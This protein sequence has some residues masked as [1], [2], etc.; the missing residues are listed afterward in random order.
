MQQWHQS[1]FIAGAGGSQRA[2][3]AEGVG[4]GVVRVMGVGVGGGGAASISS[5]TFIRDQIHKTHLPAEREGA[6]SD[7]IGI[8]GGQSER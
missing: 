8:C 4:R 1:T 5:P 6:T 2:G 3:D 7:K